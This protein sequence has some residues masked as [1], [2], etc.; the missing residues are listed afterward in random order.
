MS[1]RGIKLGDEIE[2]VTSKTAGIAIGKISYLDGGTYW[3]VQP[4][5]TDDNLK[6]D[7]VSVADAYA[8]RIGD[9]VYPKPK[10]PMGFHAREQ[11]LNG[12]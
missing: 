5:T 7:T 11:D 6:L 2:D 1:K 4:V 3:I 10:P 12:S 8:R 9:G